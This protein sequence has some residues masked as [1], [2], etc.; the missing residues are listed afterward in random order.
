ML[1]ES[2]LR[3][4]QHLL[5]LRVAQLFALAVELRSTSVSINGKYDS[6]KLLRLCKDEVSPHMWDGSAAVWSNAFTTKTDLGLPV[7]QSPL[8]R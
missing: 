2:R 3:Q 6:S 4:L 1:P 7:F 5:D 8:Q